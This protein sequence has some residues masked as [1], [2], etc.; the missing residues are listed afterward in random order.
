ML[1]KPAYVGIC[2]L[3]LSKVFMYESHHGNNKN[4]YCNNSRPSFTDTDSFEYE[5]KTEDLSEDF[6]KDKEVFGFSNYSI[7]SKYYDDSNILIVL[8][9]KGQTDDIAIEPFFGL[10]PK[11]QS[12]LVDDNSKHKKP[13]CSKEIVVETISNNKYKDFH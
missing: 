8:K 1:N 10:K 11:M 5:I 13:K 7:K 4:K 3:D 12:F 9:L 6:S 2:I